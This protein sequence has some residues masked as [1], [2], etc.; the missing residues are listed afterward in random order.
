MERFFLKLN[1]IVFYILSFLII[2]NM[3]RIGGFFEI[4]KILNYILFISILLIN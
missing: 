3:G 1:S 2:D 4:K